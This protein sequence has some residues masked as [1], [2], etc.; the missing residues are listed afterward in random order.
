M[1]EQES[2]GATKK[3]VVSS[4]SIYTGFQITMF[5]ERRKYL[6]IF[7][8]LW[9]SFLWDISYQNFLCVDCLITT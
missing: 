3:G 8:P 2:V 1:Q 4:S 6:N 9:D 7:F 5:N